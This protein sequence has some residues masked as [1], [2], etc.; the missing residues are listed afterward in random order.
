MDMKTI[1]TMFCTAV[2]LITTQAVPIHPS[3]PD[4]LTMGTATSQQLKDNV[5]MSQE[6]VLRLSQLP[7][8]NLSHVLNEVDQRGTERSHHYNVFRVR[9]W[10]HFIVS[11][12]RGP[13]TVCDGCASALAWFTGLAHKSQLD[14]VE[15]QVDNAK[16][17]LNKSGQHRVLLKRVESGPQ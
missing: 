1:L 2:N 17:N 7:L 11:K 9:A 12:H 10:I 16:R 8:I 6:M 15:G 13:R 3:P 5:S 14:R 4:N